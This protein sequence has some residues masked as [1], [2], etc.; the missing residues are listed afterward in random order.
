[1]T[2][3]ANFGLFWSFFGKKSQFILEKTKVL[4]PRYLVCIVFRLGMAD[5]GQ[6]CQYLAQN[7]QKCIF[8]TKFGLFGPKILILTG[9]NKI[10]DTHIT[11]TCPH[12]FWSGIG[13]N[14]PKMPIFGQKCHF[15]AK[16]G[17]KLTFL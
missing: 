17:P 3:N 12:C 1:M 11:K 6:K 10:F 9:G 4:A 7:Y 8:W 15:L 16:F 2:K 13:S 14:G 5:M